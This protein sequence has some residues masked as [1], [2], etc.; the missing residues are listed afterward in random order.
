MK[1]L[2]VIT[3]CLVGFAQLSFAMTPIGSYNNSYFSTTY[4]VAADQTKDGKIELYI[5]VSA[6]GADSNAKF[7]IKEENFDEFK[8]GLSF[9]KEKFAEWS[10]VATDNN[11]TDL[12]KD[13]D[14]KMPPLTIA[15]YG[16]KWYFE[17][18]KILKPRFSVLDAERRIIGSVFDAKASPNKYID[19]TIY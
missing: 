3:L 2:L 14:V 9:M 5:E 19:K 17:F 6:K 10:K 12:T 11:V 13:V 15:W 4:S 7:I 1:R 18:G 8:V 16:T